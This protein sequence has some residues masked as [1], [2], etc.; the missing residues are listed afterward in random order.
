MKGAIMAPL[1]VGKI[2]PEILGEFLSHY[3]RK[4]DR[5]IIGASIGEDAAVI[6][7]GPILLVAKTD[8]IT[9]VTTE[10]GRYAVHIN[11][12]DIAAMGGRPRW[13][14][15]AVLVPPGAEA[16]DIDLILSHISQSC[17]EIGV[18]YCGGHT[19]VT[20][21]VNNPVVIGQMLGEV[22][23][24]N[25]KPSSGGKEGD[26]LIMTKTA[27]L[28]ATAIIALEKGEEL[29]NHFP[30]EMI[31]RAQHYLREPGISV[32][33]EGRLMA[34]RKSVH[35]LHDPTEGG[36][37]TGIFEIATASNLGAEVYHDRIPITEE[38]RDLCAHYGINPL[39][40]FASGSLLI[41]V[42]RDD[43]QQ[44]MNALTT[45]GI[46]AARIGK[47]VKKEEGLK[48]IKRGDI[49]P[50]PLFHQDELSKIFG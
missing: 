42:S 36:I 16:G 35:A 20:T 33:K 28:E 43:S 9:H 34:L 49:K 50:L 47:L 30:E 39:G 18:V 26:D 10:I 25:L 38:T 46:A 6:D 11:A 7:M 1:P 12:N 17:A 45:A 14:L 44:T 19:E 23:R 40:A 2:H 4:D 8:P 3:T 29:K 15:A 24:E 5:V 13:Y 48:L 22:T 31:R 27:A 32:L 41:A 37:A 21:S